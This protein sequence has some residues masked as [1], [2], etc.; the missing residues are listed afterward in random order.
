[1]EDVHLSGLAWMQAATKR[2]GENLSERTRSPDVE[3][4][5]RALPTRL[6][7]PTAACLHEV[8]G[9]LA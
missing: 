2:R 7:V 4:P 1:M 5:P 3:W 9:M 8:A 6:P